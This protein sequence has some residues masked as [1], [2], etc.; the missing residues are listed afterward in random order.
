MTLPQSNVSRC[1]YGQSFTIFCAM[2]ARETDECIVWP[3]AKDPRGSGI[4]TLGGPRGSSY[5]ELAHRLAWVV[6]HHEPIDFIRV[7]Q[8]CK[9]VV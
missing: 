7:W 8:R 5:S 3:Y 6:T 1:S 9:N 2:L 4:V